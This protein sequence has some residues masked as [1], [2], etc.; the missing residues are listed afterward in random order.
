MTLTRS[1]AIL[2]VLAAAALFGTS[3]TARALTDVDASATAV[4]ALRLA[5]GAGGLLVIARVQRTGGIRALLAQPSVWLM[6]AAVAGYQAL[7]FLGT[8]RTGVAMGTLIS[9]A[10]APFAAGLL[11]WRLG[12]RRPSAQWA[13]ST[14]IA[15]L[16]LALLTGSG[17]ITD[18]LGV[19]AA[20][21]AGACY[22]VYTV[23]GV[24]IIQSGADSTAVLAAAFTLGALLVSPW[25]VRESSVLGD[26][27][28]WFLALWL[29]LAATTLAYVLFGFGL[30]VLPAGTVATLNLAEPA[31][32][33][34]LG[35]VILNESLGLWG[36][37]GC[38]IIVMALVLVARD[39]GE[40]T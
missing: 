21:G 20:L 34:M 29:G 26:P 9:L 11:A 25:L 10:L 28:T 4:A 37:L 14:L 38:G 35:V 16:G 5:V 17:G 19:I 27:A 31:M 8:D 15:V 36:A 32:A 40:H 1:R 39:P 3:A 6:G 33:T 13:M 24:R 12:A 7:F 18:G 22:A 2:A 23:L 30:R